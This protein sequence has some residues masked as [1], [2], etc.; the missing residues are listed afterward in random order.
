M[1]KKGRLSKSEINTIEGLHKSG[2]PSKEIATALNR[3]DKIVLKNIDEI[4]TQ[5]EEDKTEEVETKKRQSQFQQ[6]VV[7]KGGATIMTGGASSTTNE[8]AE[9]KIGSKTRRHIYDV[10]GN[11]KDG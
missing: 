9:T 1:L 5:K 8:L 4:N 10:H 7:Q 6:S 3:S 2:M 11:L